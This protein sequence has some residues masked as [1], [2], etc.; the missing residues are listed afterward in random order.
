M[1]NKQKKYGDSDMYVNKITGAYYGRRSLYEVLFFLF[2]HWVIEFLMLQNNKYNLKEVK[3]FHGN[4][5]VVKFQRI[6]NP[7]ITDERVWHDK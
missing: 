4:L 2:I 7:A 5:T 3:Q 6:L 1:K